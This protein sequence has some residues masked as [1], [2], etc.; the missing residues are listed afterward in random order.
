MNGAA[1]SG[2]DT[3]KAVM[4]KVSGAKTARVFSRRQFVRLG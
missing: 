1:Q 2:A 4:G 3:A